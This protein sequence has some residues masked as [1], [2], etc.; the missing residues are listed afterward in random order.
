MSWI[1]YWQRIISFL[2]HHNTRG[3]ALH[4]QVPDACLVA[5]FHHISELSLATASSHQFVRDGLVALKPRAGRET[6]D[7]VLMGWGNLKDK[8][9]MSVGLYIQL[10]IKLVKLPNSSYCQD[11]SLNPLVLQ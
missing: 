1:E 3:I 9:A 5:A 7:S 4:L 2:F 6:D 11:E 8:H 10:N